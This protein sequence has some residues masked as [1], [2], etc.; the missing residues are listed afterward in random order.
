MDPFTLFF[1]RKTAEVLRTP[2]LGVALN[3]MTLVSLMESVL[4]VELLGL[5]DLDLEPL[6]LQAQ[7]IDS[8]VFGQI[9]I[10]IR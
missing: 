2:A 8:S 3:R 4:S 10:K 5:R 1:A 6:P 9:H 7:R